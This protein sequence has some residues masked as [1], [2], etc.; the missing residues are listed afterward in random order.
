MG[1]PYLV[2]LGTGF[3]SV[4]IGKYTVPGEDTP[5]TVLTVLF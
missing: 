1:I 4:V 5:L 2:I 3:C